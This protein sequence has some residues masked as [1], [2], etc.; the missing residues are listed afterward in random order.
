[1]H[2]DY[3]L[4]QFRIQKIIIHVCIIFNLKSYS[5]FF[6]YCYELLTQLKIEWSLRV[7]SLDYHMP[8]I[9]RR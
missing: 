2:S 9:P 3:A 7:E 1:M 5:Y 4:I 8:M 6:L